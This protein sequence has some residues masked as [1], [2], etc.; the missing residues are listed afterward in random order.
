MTHFYKKQSLHIIVIILL[1]FSSLGNSISVIAETTKESTAGQISESTDDD[2][3]TE[4]DELSRE[5]PVESGDAQKTY[6]SEE[7]IPEV[8]KEALKVDPGLRVT[9]Q[10]LTS[11][12]NHFI[13]RFLQGDANV[14]G[15]TQFPTTYANFFANDSRA[16]VSWTGSD[17][18]G[19]RAGDKI[20]G[21]VNLP[22]QYLY[23]ESPGNSRGSSL[24]AGVSAY[25]MPTR[26]DYQ[27]GN[28]V[29]QHSQGDFLITVRESSTYNI[30]AAVA[31]STDFREGVLADFHEF[32]IVVERVRDTSITS[33]RT[34]SFTIDLD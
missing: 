27:F 3:P 17:Q 18:L 7:K 31:S 5:V 9:L 33:G 1:L 28:A 21:T 4:N 23:H 30:K 12:N 10:L 26:N 25:S 16:R 34:N 13:T 19:N 8:D 15:R 29:I 20:E 11:L 24:Q 6:A 22:R 14:S 2:S 32:S